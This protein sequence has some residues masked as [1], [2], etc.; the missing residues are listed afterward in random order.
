MCWAVF[1]I[2][3]RFV[4]LW[5]PKSLQ[6]TY[7]L[8]WL[9]HYPSNGC[10]MLYIVET[11]IPAY[12]LIGFGVSGVFRREKLAKNSL[13][14]SEISPN[15]LKFSY[16]TFRLI[17]DPLN[18]CEM[19]YIVETHTPE[20]SFINFWVSGVFQREK[21]PQNS[22]KLSKISP[23]PLKFSYYLLWLTHDPFNGCEML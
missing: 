23:K 19:L 21:L 6:F 15:L 20:Y 5:A 9:T 18:G 22:R 17:H 14:L 11:N 1:R 7:C 3:P 2:Y 13:K 16:C 10:E 12:Y 4:V 8:L